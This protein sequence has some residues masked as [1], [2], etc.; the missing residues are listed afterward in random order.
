MRSLAYE[1]AG[2]VKLFCLHIGLLM[3]SNLTPSAFR[4]IYIASTP[5]YK[6]K[7]PYELFKQYE[8]CINEYLDAITKL[9][10]IS[11]ESNEFVIPR[12]IPSAR[13]V[14]VNLWA[15][16][17]GATTLRF[18]GLDSGLEVSETFTQ[19]MRMVCDNMNW[20][21]LSSDFDYDAYGEIARRDIFEEYYKLPALT[22]LLEITPI[23]KIADEHPF[24]IVM[25]PNLQ[26][27]PESKST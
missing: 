21:P 5:Q 17:H 4:C 22:A 11:V 13:S 14:A 7:V 6:S 19:Y 20:L 12:G 1:A 3:H 23:I 15:A 24:E 18:S 8:E 2:R 16:H 26:A 9:V 10:E 25:E 27:A